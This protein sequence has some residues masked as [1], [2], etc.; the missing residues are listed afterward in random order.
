MQMQ[1]RI[2]ALAAIGCAAAAMA[3]P[4]AAAQAVTSPAAAHAISVK[5]PPGARVI[6]AEKLPGW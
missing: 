1:L 6:L 2:A 3:L 4:S 5:A